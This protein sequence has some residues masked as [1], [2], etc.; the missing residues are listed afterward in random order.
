LHSVTQSH[1]FS[2]EGVSYHLTGYA[3]AR[4]NFAACIFL[5]CFL[6][7]GKQENLQEENNMEK[8]DILLKIDQIKDDLE[9]DR[10]QVIMNKI[11]EREFHLHRSERNVFLRWLIRRFRKRLMLE[12]QLIMEPEQK[13]QKEI[14]IRFLNELEKIKR[15]LS[16]LE[17]NEA[18]TD[19]EPETSKSHPKNQG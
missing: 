2:N 1:C 8:E 18:G 11:Q 9:K 6:Y 10:F 12:I 19:H 3:V 15:R 17:K 14:N 7:Q 13:K 16:F 5:A 4:Y